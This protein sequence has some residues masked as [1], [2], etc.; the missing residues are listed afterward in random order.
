[1]GRQRS[2]SWRF[3]AWPSA[4]D[5][6]RH[7]R[8][9]YVEDGVSIQRA[10][11]PG[12]E[13]AERQ[14]PLPPR[15][16]RLDRRPRA[17]SSSSSTAGAFLRL[18]SGTKL[19]YLDNPGDRVVLRLWSGGLY[20]HQAGG[21]DTD[22]EIETPG[23]VVS[24]RGR[25]VY[26][27]D[28]RSRRDARLRVRGRGDPRGRPRRARPRGRARVRAATARSS[29]GP[30]AF[31][32]AGRG[33]LRDVGRRPA[34][35]ACATPASGRPDLPEDAAPYYDELYDHGSW[36]QRAEVGYV[37]RPRVALG[38]QPYSHGRWIWT[39][40]GWTWV[41]ARALGLG[42]VP[43]RPLGILAGRAGTGSRS[44]A[45]GRPG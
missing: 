42:A 35:A 36:Y 40:Y 38:W 45:G 17:A 13:E 1:M 24:T 9:R 12:A 18:D 26:R 21:G 39:A 2:W 3:P 5:D 19:D 8:V 16:P 32:R 6:Y 43:L 7:G 20:V 23:G 10:A 29:A 33:R 37:W 31:D 41:A 30:M 22:F 4:D 27:I 44:A 11:E 25:G 15:R 28:A 34:G 14:H